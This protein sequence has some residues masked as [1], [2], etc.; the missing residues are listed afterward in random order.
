MLGEGCG[1]TSI[2]VQPNNMLHMVK[3]SI[4][5][6][7]GP[8]RS[9]TGSGTDIGQASCMTC[10]MRT[11]N[12]CNLLSCTSN[13]SSSWI[14]RAWHVHYQSPVLLRCS[15]PEGHKQASHMCIADA[16]KQ[17]FTCRTRRQGGGPFIRS[18]SSYCDLWS[19]TLCRLIMASLTR[20]AAPPC[21]R[22]RDRCFT[23]HCRQNHTQAQ[24]VAAI[25]W[26]WPCHSRAALHHVRKSLM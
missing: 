12:S 16:G 17:L 21:R 4:W 20:S 14:Y 9:L 3:V 5:P 10:L 23:Q 22:V 8:A 26:A 13:S 7:L 15:M 19:S 1:T 25:M 2:K 18:G 24:T 11:A 6:Q